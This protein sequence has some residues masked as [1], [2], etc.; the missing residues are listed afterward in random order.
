MQLML[1]ISEHEFGNLLLNS[2]E[3]QKLINTNKFLVAREFKVGSAV[4]DFV[5]ISDQDHKSIVELS[6]I[7]P[8]EVF[9]G[10]NSS[11]IC[12]LYGPSYVKDIRV[13]AQSNFT[14]TENVLKAARKLQNLNII[15]LDKD[16]ARMSRTKDFRLPSIDVIS[17]ELKL[18]KWKKALWQAS[19]NQAYYAKS[20]VVMP[21]DK[22]ELIRKNRDYFSVS[23]VSAVVV[24]T[25][26]GGVKFV[27][28]NNTR[29]KQLLT[30]QRLAGLS[31][32]MQRQSSFVEFSV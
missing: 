14:S 20:Y 25:A 27:A 1:K 9:R 32:L 5:L 2:A 11:V 15:K 18:D 4:P 13:I 22:E 19:R 21:A 12:M 6:A 10:I 8:P 30:T 17:L 23:G 26:K 28:R 3:I 7:Y 31:Y 16:E 29:K 24:D